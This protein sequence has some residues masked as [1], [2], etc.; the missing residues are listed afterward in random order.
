MSHVGCVI[1]R[2]VVDSLI[3]DL[4]T[5]QITAENMIDDPIT[6]FYQILLYYTEF[7]AQN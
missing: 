2:A 5:D 4:D 3:M 6:I 7:I 1:G